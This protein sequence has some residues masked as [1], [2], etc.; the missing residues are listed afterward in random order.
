MGTN[1]FP[2][3]VAVA[4]VN[5]DGQ[6]DLFTANNGNNTV[7]VL[8]GNGNGTFQAAT[9]YGT[10]GNNPI[11]IAVADVNGDGKL[12]LLTTNRNSNTI[13]VLLGNG[14]GTF[15]PMA[16]TY[17]TGGTNPMGLAAADVNGDG[18]PD[19]LTV[20]FN[21]NTIGV[22]LNTTIYA[23]PTL[24]SINPTSA[25]G[26]TTITLTGT[27][28]T[29]ATA[30][31]FNGTAATTF[32]VVNSSTVTVTVPPGATSGNVTVTTPSGTTGGLL[33]TV[34][35]P[36]LVVD[37][38]TTIPAGIYNSIRVTSTGAGTL[39]G[40]VTVNTSFT[41]QRGGT[42]TDGCALI[43]G[44][45]SFTLAEGA[46]LSICAAQGISSSSASGAVQVTGSRA[47]S[48]AAS[49]VYNG[50][51][52][53][54]TGDGLPS[55]VRNLSTTNDNPVTLSAAISVSQVVTVG[56]LGN[57]VLNGNLLTLLSSSAGTALVVNTGAGRVLGNTVVVQRYIDGSLNRGG[58]YHHRFYSRSESGL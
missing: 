32:V 45:G 6:L 8:L 57:L 54:V 31:S 14:N 55:Q 38:P 4:D 58:L 26:G 13:G 21:S 28:L 12:D 53:Q 19:L 37:T 25:A 36:D 29:G 16:T 44:A 51:V 5:G 50:S 24:T 49:Y 33:F 40:D 7:G 2:Y 46:T 35:Y 18:K 52:A 30:V 42:L 23:A 3:S 15:Q 27:N 47:F 41:V 11:S 20:N 39:A 1:S 34:T 48:P 56:G 10:S 22:L 9:T 17:S 43:R